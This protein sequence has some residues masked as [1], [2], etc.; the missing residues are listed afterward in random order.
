MLANAVHVGRALRG[1]KQVAIAEHHPSGCASCTSGKQ[2]DGGIVA[3]D[4]GGLLF[5]KVRVLY[6]IITTAGLHG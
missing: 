6:K 3:A 4:D 5:E 1:F 2:N